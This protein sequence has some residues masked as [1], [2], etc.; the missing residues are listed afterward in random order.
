LINTDLTGESLS[1]AVL[2]CGS[3]NL[4]IGTELLDSLKTI[5]DSKLDK[6]FVYNGEEENK[7]SH[8]YIDLDEILK[9]CSTNQPKASL[10]S[11]ITLKSP[12]F[13]IFTSG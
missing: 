12:A 8:K 11:D 7:V 13:L 5:D 10:R 6:I 2:S 4:I 3:K 9:N 1:H